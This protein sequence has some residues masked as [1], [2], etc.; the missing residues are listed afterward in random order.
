MVKTAVKIGN[1]L[2]KNPVIAASGTFGFG[3]EMEKWNDLSELGGICSKGLTEN[4]R[5]GNDPPRVAETAGGMLNSVGLQ[6]PGLAAFIQVELPYMKTL[7]PSIIANIAGHS[8]AENVRMAEQLDAT[9]VDAIELNLSC[10][11]VS[12]GCMAFGSSAA[13][14]AAVVSAVRTKTKKPLWVKL[15]PNVTSITE[16]AQAAEA[17]GADAISL[18]NTLMGLAVDRRTRRRFCVTTPAGF[19]VP[20][21]N[22]WPCGW[23]WRLI[24]LFT[25]RSLAWAEFFPVR[26]LSNS[27]WPVLPRSRWEPPS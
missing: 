26:M 21:L 1:L 22:L 15:T 8:L 2:L 14:I 18:I 20:P 5:L 3:H 12:E 10:P 25:F 4:P 6:N 23:F 19:P 16:M 11:N 27:C 7:G 24:R 9:S 17:A 13:M